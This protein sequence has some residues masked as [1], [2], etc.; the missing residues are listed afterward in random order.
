MTLF[1]YNPVN[2]QYLQIKKNRIRKIFIEGFADWYLN[3]YRYLRENPL[4]LWSKLAEILNSPMNKKTIVFSMKAFDI[5]NLICHGDYLP[6]PL[7]IPI[8][9]D[10]HIKRATISAGL[11]DKYEDDELFRHVWSL[12]LRKVREKIGRNITLLRLDSIVWQIGKILYSCGYEKEPSRKSIEKY[13]TIKI[14]VENALAKK[15]AI[16]LTQFINHV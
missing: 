4:I 7:D 8:P 9:V 12:V 11:L 16:E 3:N 5:S 15:I 1:L 2:A 14:G 6:F 10:F 13:L